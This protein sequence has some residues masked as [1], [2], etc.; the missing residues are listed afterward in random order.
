MRGLLTMRKIE[1]GTPITTPGIYHLPYE[2]LISLSSDGINWVTIADKNLGATQVY[3]DGDTLSEANCWKFYQWW[4]NYGFPF[5]WSVTT[6]NGEVDTSWYWPLNYYENSTFIIPSMDIRDWS[7][8]NNPDL[9]WDTTDT[10][11]ARRW[12]CGQWQHIPDKNEIINLGNIMTSLNLWPNLSSISTYLHMPRGWR[13]NW[14]T[15]SVADSTSWFYFSSSTYNTTSSRGS[16]YLSFN[17]NG[18]TF[19]TSYTYRAYWYLIRPFA[20]IPVI[21]KIAETIY[22]QADGNIIYAQDTTL[23]QWTISTTGSYLIQTNLNS[24][25]NRS[26]H[27]YVYKKNGQQWTLEH[28]FVWGNWR[29]GIMTYNFVWNAWDVIWLQGDH[30]LSGE[31]VLIKD[32]KFQR[33]TA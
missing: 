28:D 3:N 23:W 9:W 10:L 25:S 13:R 8:N 2:W 21:P 11:Q 6:S 17:A 5:S 7:S 22:S 19:W 18:T 20:N 32:T 33:I 16:Y 14:G 4:N 30:A 31:R 1:N 26:W 24:Q 15:S 29:T 27:L 12:P